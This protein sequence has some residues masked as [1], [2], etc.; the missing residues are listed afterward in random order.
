[1]F[2]SVIEA[3]RAAVAAFG[4]PAGDE[5][6]GSR[7]GGGDDQDR[8]E[9]RLTPAGEFPG[10]EV[11]TDLGEDGLGVGDSIRFSKVLSEDDVERF[12]AASGDTNPLHLDEEF[13]ATTR[14]DG[15]I[16]HGMLATGLIS[17]ALARL[18]GGVVYLSQDT[19]F[20]RPIRIGDRVTAVVEA[21]EDL[22]GGRYRLSTR[23][24]DGDDEVAV[25]GEATVL[26]E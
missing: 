22:G 12:A 16:V 1:M 18:P 15:R 3:N 6:N 7:G 20:L 8:L 2:N 9:D 21:V 26:I 5:G 25:D 17:A 11:T 4:G 24:L 23:V 13:A 10:W 19:E 14:F